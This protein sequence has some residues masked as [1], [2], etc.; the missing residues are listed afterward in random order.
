M[1]KFLETLSVFWRAGRHSLAL[2]FRNSRGWTIA[3]LVITALTTTA[4]YLVLQSTGLVVNAVQSQSGH[5][6][7]VMPWM[8]IALFLVVMFANFLLRRANWYIQTKWGQFLQ[9]ANRRELQ[10]HKAT[11]DVGVAQSKKFDDLDKRISELPYGQESPIRFVQQMFDLLATVVSFFL[12]GMA[13][14]WYN[15]AYAGFLFVAALPMV[16][17]EFRQNGYWWDL[18]EKMVPFNKLRW[19]LEAAYKE[20]TAFVQALMWN[21]PKSL[22]KKIDARYGE[23]LAE[24]E[25]VRRKVLFGEVIVHLISTASLGV[26]VVHVIWT[27]LH[28]GS[29]LGTMTVILASARTFQGNL[30][31]IAASTSEQLNTAKGVLLLHEEFFNL[32]PHIKTLDPIVPDFQTAPSIHLDRISFT[33]P[34]KLDT[35]ILHEVSAEIP[36]GKIT[37]IVGKNGSGKSTIQ[38]LLQRH[39]DPTTGALYFD[40]INAKN[41]EPSC[42]NEIVTTQA[43]EYRILPRTVKEEL[44][45]S[46]MDTEIDVDKMVEASRF[47]RFEE[48]ISKDELGYDTQIGTDFGGREF[49]GG[50]RQRLAIARVRYRDTPV[51]IYDEPDASLDP[52]ASQELMNRIL[53]LKNK[54]VV[55][56]TQH[57]SKTLECDHVIVMENGR[58]IEQGNPRELYASGGRYASLFISDK[59]RTGDVETKIGQ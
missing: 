34:E 57:V 24:Y 52:E 12:Y 19:V 21:Q 13:L 56:I 29:G 8:P 36:G 33:Y 14:A 22:R 32:E 18:W 31:D 16:F 37:A 47:A 15:P 2:C 27:T 53:S 23:E 44:T 59:K 48:V 11:L 1:G 35:E 3:R 46:R 17:V 38:K 41:I 51:M 43:Q 54:T 30:E 4:G 5:K 10:E 45:S 7:K 39:Y 50:Q 42:L 20:K 40:D 55:V 28:S 49:S 26:V 25:T 58:V 6:D 9:K